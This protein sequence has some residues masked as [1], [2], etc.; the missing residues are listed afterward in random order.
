MGRHGEHEGAA[1]LCADVHRCW[2]GLWVRVRVRVRVG[3]GGQETDRWMLS[4]VLLLARARMGFIAA[5]SVPCA[6][7]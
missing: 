5:A 2:L 3:D 7:M 4:G 1:R 6:S